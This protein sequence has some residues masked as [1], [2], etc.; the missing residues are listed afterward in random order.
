MVREDTVVLI[1]AG[2]WVIPRVGVCRHLN[3][4]LALKPGLI[5]GMFQNEYLSE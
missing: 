5:H 3:V 4:F 1:F 2:A